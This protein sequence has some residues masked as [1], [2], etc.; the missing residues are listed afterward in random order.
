ML[1]QAWHPLSPFQR[2]LWRF[3]QLEPESRAYNLGFFVRLK[4][5]LDRGRL[6]T[7]L[8]DL[9]ARH[10]ML[11]ARFADGRQQILPPTPRRLDEE[12]R[13]ETSDPADQAL[14]RGH[15]FLL[16]PYD[17]EAGDVFRY[18][19]YRT[20]EGH[21]LLAVG[22]HHIVCD[23]WSIRLLI[24]E[25]LAL[26]NGQRLRPVR[27]RYPDYARQLEDW[28]EGPEAAVQKDYWQRSLGARRPVLTLPALQPPGNVH[29]AIYHPLSA[30]AELV[31]GI[32]AL[33]ERLKATRFNILLAALQV[34]LSRLSGQP[35]ARVGILSS[36]RSARSARTVGF[37]VNTLP[38]GGIPHP[39]LS[40]EDWIRQV[41]ENLD[42][43]R[44]NGRAPLDSL[45]IDGAPVPFHFA[46]NYHGRRR[47]ERDLV[48]MDGLDVDF[49]EL[50]LAETPFALTLDAAP[51]L[52]NGVVL[53]FI[54][55]EG[56]FDD[57]F[58]TLVKN[59]YMAVLRQII[60]SPESALGSLDL[61][62]SSDAALLRSWAERPADYDRG[63][64]F[65]DLVAAQAAA[66]PEAVALVHG[67]ERVSYAEL[68]R[69]STAI[70]RW[71]QA[72]GAGPETVVGVALE[73]GTAMIA[74]FLG[75]LKA[76]A[77]FLPLDPDYPPERLRHMLDDSGAPLLLTSS[78]LTDRLTLPEATR[79]VALDQLDI[80]Q[81]QFAEQPQ[82]SPLPPVHPDQLAY[83]IYTSGSTGQP[84]GVA[85]TRRGL[86]MHVQTIGQ[87]YGMTP[88]DTELLFASISF[89]GALERWTVPLA[90]G[91]R[92]V[93]RDQALWSAEQT[94]EAL[95][96]EGVTIACF[97]PSY[98]GPLL[99]WIEH[100][101]P[102][103]PLRSWTLGG[104]AFTR[105][106]YHRLQRLARPPRII[107]GY[108][109]TETVVTPMIWEAYPDTPLDSAYAPIGTPVGERR[110]YVLDQT[111]N[112]VPPGSPGEL[113]IGGEAGLARGYH[114]RPELT[115]E[116]FLPD[117]FGPPGERMYRTGDRVRWRDDG[118]R[119]GV[120]EYLGRADQQIKIRGFRIEPG[121]IEARLMALPELREAVVVAQSRDGEAAAAML[122]AYVVPAEN[123]PAGD[124]DSRAIQQRLGEDLP[125]YM[126][127]ARIVALP[128]LPLTPAGKV[129]R[130]ALPA[131]AIGPAAQEAP[132]G[133]AEEAMAAIWQRLL[134]CERL[135][136]QDSFFELGGDS[137]LALQV[138]AQARQAGWQ[139]RPNHLFQHQTLAA[140]AQAA[141]PQDAKDR[142]HAA[143]APVTGPAKLTP[144]Q[145]HFFALN[146]RVPSHW[147]QHLWLE[148]QA[149]L[150]LEALAAAL[151]ALRAHH[152]A[153]RLRF[154]RHDGAWRQRFL[155]PDAPP[156]D[157]PA[158]LLWHRQAAD[159]AEAEALCTQA[160]QSLDIETGPLLR[161]LYLTQPGR[162]DR[163]LLTIHH[164]AVDGVSW[165]I[166]I[167]DLRLAYSQ[168]AAGQEIRLP[169]KTG[170]LKD[171][172]EALAKWPD[173]RNQIPFWQA[174]QAD[175]ATLWGSRPTG[176]TQSHKLVLPA[177]IVRRAEAAA[178]T[179]LRSSLDELVFAAL[180]LS[181]AKCFERRRVRIHRE[182]H[183]RDP[184]LAAGD[185][186]RTVG[187]FTSLYPLLVDV[188]DDR[189][190]A[191]KSIKE[192]IR[193]LPNHG[194]AYGVLKEQ[195]ALDG[196][197]S[198]E[199]IF[200]Y[201]GRLNPV[202]GMRVRDSGLWRP[203]GS[204]ADAPLVVDA[205]QEPDGTLS[206]NLAVSSGQ[207]AFAKQQAFLT[208]L[209]QEITALIR[210]CEDGGPWLT[211]SDVPL[212]SLDQSDL[213]AL[214]AQGIEDV[215]PLT[216]LQQ[217][218]LFHT[219]LSRHRDTYVNQ[220]SIPV[221]DIEPE[222]FRSVWQQLMDRHPVLRSAPLDHDGL[223][224]TW[225]ALELPWQFHALAADSD[226][227]RICAERR[228]FDLSRPPLWHVD[229]VETGDST[230]L[231]VLTL[232]HLVMDGW[233]TTVLLDEAMRLYRG[234]PL[235]PAA[236]PF[237]TFLQ[238]IE[239][240]EAEKAQAFWRNY[241]EDFPATLVA[242][243]KPGGDQGGDK[244]YRRHTL[245]LPADLAERARRLQV[246]QSTLLQG[247]WALTLAQHTGRRRVVFG[248]TVAGRPSDLSGSERMT[249]LFINTLPVAV[250]VAAG[251]ENWL[252]ALQQA[253]AD[254]REHG[255]LPLFEIQR[256]AGHARAGLF[257]S[258][259]VFENYPGLE[260]L[261]GEIP[262]IYEFTH[263]PL[264]LAIMPGE[265]PKVVFAYDAAALPPDTVEALA[266]SFGQALATL[267]DGGTST[268]FGS[269][270]ASGSEV[271]LENAASQGSPAQSTYQ[272]PRGKSEERLAALWQEVLEVPRVGRQDD[273]F[274]LGGH[275][276]LA[277]R[278]VGL[279]RSR[280]DLQLPLQALFD[281]PRLADCAARLHKAEE[282]DAGFVA[283][284]RSGD[285]EASPAQ[286]RLWFIQQLAPEDG[287]Y[288]LPLGLELRGQLDT[289]ALAAALNQVVA[290]HEILRT[291]LVADGGEVRQRLLPHAPIEVELHDLR[292][293]PDP[294]GT[295]TALFKDWLERPFDLARDP[296]LRLGVVQREEQHFRLLLVQHHSV[297]DGRSTRLF[298]HELIEAYRG[299]LAGAPPDALP[300]QP[301]QYA[302][303]AKWYSGWLD[304]PA[305]Q[306]QRA[307]WQEKLEAA[308]EPI[309][310]PTDFAR[311][312]AV[313]EGARLP[314]R[315]PPRL[316]EAV[317]ALGQDETTTLSSVLLA[318][319][320][321]LLH[322]Y[323][324]KEEIRVGVPV[325][326]RTRP[327]T[328]DMLGCF[329][330]VV[331]LQARIDPQQGF[332]GLVKAVAADS[333]TAQQHQELPFEA[334]VQSLGA[335]RDPDRHPLFQV[336]FNHQQDM[337]AA[338]TG[339]PEAEV[340]AFDPGSA[341]AQFDL[342]LD[343]EVHPDGSISGFVSYDRGLFRDSTAVRLMAHYL[344]LLEAVCAAPKRPLGAIDLLLPEEHGRLQ[345]WSETGRDWGAFVPVPVRQ[346]RQAAQTPNA[347]ALSFAGEE[348]TYAAL[349]RRVNQ[350]AHRLQRAGVGP[351]TP[352]AVCMQRSPEMV[353]ALLAIVRAGGSYLPLDPDYPAERMAGILE[354]ARPLLAFSDRPL[355]DLPCW[356]VNDPASEEEPAT[357]PDVDWHPD[358]AMYTIYTSGSTGRPKGVVNS[359]AALENRLLWMQGQYPLGEGDCVLQKT[360]FGFDVSVWEFFWPFMT[361]ARLAVAPPEAHADPQA[362]RAV[363]DAERVTTLHFVPSM[364]QAALPALGGCKTIKRIICSGEALS[365]EL[366]RE[367]FS[368]LPGVELHNLYGPTE[369][370]ID[371]SYW[372]CR[373]DGRHTVPIGVP[374]ANI[375]L[376]VLD[377]CL[378]AVADGVPGE[379]YLSGIGL[380][381]GYLGRPDLTAE[382]FLPD[383]AGPPASRMYRT[384]DL[385][386]RGEDGVIEYLGRLDHQVK[387]RGLR[388]ELGEV[389]AALR[390]LEEIADAVVVVHEALLAAYIVPAT[391][392]GERWR[393]DIKAKLAELLPA[394]MV[395]SFFTALEAFPLSANGK[396]N[397]KAL[398][399][400]EAQRR[401]YRGPR[402]V[403]E[404]RLAEIWQE[405]LDCDAVGLDDNF[406]DLGGYSLAAI[407]AIA[408]V[409]TRFDRDVPL[410]AFVGSETLEAL[411]AQL[412]ETESPDDD[413]EAM[414]ALLDDVSNA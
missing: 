343:T 317:R 170:S 354:E 391:V 220:L 173:A 27:L 250:D 197:A 9:V 353:L 73:R 55:A 368:T 165:R 218:L 10:E 92:L 267:S 3:A 21:H 178:R 34:L 19:L 57:A 109:P 22:I 333:L 135:G 394:Y 285:L 384:G 179:S 241:L 17:L 48:D 334:V 242:E 76:G 183:G 137:I 175:G 292:S 51:D 116:R 192:R 213:D 88:E 112:P 206:L 16:Q 204:R 115:A 269:G 312:S 405:V 228:D 224:G 330:N 140:V 8:S 118:V 363:I 383:P 187:W 371:V 223:Q 97:P 99:D 293:H 283:T 245:M 399:S 56:V 366:Q 341:G 301:L 227:E 273:F 264:T 141:T 400:P 144:I 402:S 133:A 101:R 69:R 355:G 79:T 249:G 214:A 295:E 336:V 211:P 113:Y 365:L 150:D 212:A 226:V 403:T 235:A 254:A 110:A 222:R 350:L 359:H 23:A 337:A 30:D 102:D 185:L 374:I 409:R 24:T 70:A 332:A 251:Q 65:V 260:D 299:H 255:Y 351:E 305:A 122:V 247:S 82:D 289:A 130:Q 265:A 44:A 277:L 411:A 148:A 410:R 98:A 155:A 49:Q 261:P 386:R 263:Y 123:G 162:P 300:P 329:I 309:D 234:E 387:I 318:A 121:E 182:S 216:S 311:G 367:T 378:N 181:L 53:R 352:V 297:T 142:N 126:V 157:L 29:R 217:G 28:E 237:S 316:T 160:Q 385:V 64:D 280:Y 127:P 128:S 298:L 38:L 207:I 4:G 321:L 42:E 36:D 13:S 345:A 25:L 62:S 210:C 40:V 342:A 358:Q 397:R 233:S 66:Q 266:Q 377:S 186:S 145:A 340:T 72:Q 158:D 177:G 231:F 398:P 78:D 327:E 406:F 117:P 322:R 75:A 184:D 278:I 84:K 281:H 114:G 258:L 375:R 338:F 189:T 282:D 225:R 396:L 244:D 200:N 156:R 275:S 257:D 307:Y 132:Q 5:S 152:D 308:T 230:C 94:C 149:P 1:E 12:D 39:A 209:E 272:P 77:A 80:D 271:M 370:A 60:G 2:H 74:A 14:E 325:S 191:L 320:M 180:A 52:D 163:L 276:L 388:V 103:L 395:P 46:F 346:S 68:E 407:R 372:R 96:S 288:H 190:V 139:I 315:L 50:L 404:R 389:E 347:V 408:L 119:G 138:V 259:M 18:R 43:A 348:W 104:E 382:R 392:L 284:G 168:A 67:Q 414:A 202:E 6:E 169:D 248:N 166:L 326:G 287:A 239:E 262:Q 100:A 147:N 413:L 344:N 243:Q 294:E 35:S 194:L 20:A 154:E 362:L 58:M 253:G 195:G 193:H 15:A 303:Y 31:A 369:A 252:Q 91:A 120:M 7:A 93:I 229:L 71:L 373:D 164:L 161:A 63:A 339:W 188:A 323:S 238:W 176:Q 143:Q 356:Q 108:G 199:V 380:A 401:Q 26:Y 221:K 349:E 314:F 246:T 361:G 290:R 324:G 83:I 296:L 306:R 124:I 331:T 215:L 125:A 171:W 364:L 291:R 302:D 360:P 381:R 174:Q 232:H 41:G 105:E 146:P 198:P 129:D 203:T 319:W 279:A 159:D 167:E 412:E 205:L 219:R 107:N 61:L 208:T 196:T 268:V 240:Q 172:T 286:R 85:V 32:D 131:P 11:R 86:A 136:R 201:L 256:M 90:F 357:P 59:S 47:G 270:F 335:G 313:S 236:P 37:F 151:L 111:L 390:H 304:S 153:L 54:A 106:T 274:G 379:L 95:I 376:Q 134:K 87:R 393:D 45:Q 81:L 328:E 89:D 310:L 33:A